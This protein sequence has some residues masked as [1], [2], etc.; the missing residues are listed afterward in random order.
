[1]RAKFIYTRRLTIS[2]LK[3]DKTT[4]Q[5]LVVGVIVLVWVIALIIAA[6]DG[7]VMLKATTPLMTLVFGWLFAAKAIGEP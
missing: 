4:L 6:F 5:L 7:S 2:P 3:L 1:M